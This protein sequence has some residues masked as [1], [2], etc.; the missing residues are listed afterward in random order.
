MP[1]GWAFG[2]RDA[3]GVTRMLHGAATPAPG[4]D[5][6]P[7]TVPR[8]RLRGLA[9]RSRARTAAEL[10]LV[11]AGVGGST[12]LEIKWATSQP[13]VGALA[14]APLATLVDDLAW[15]ADNGLRVM[16]RTYAG[17]YAPGFVR[18]AAGNIAPW[19]SKDNPPTYDWE[20]IPGGL[21]NWTKPAFA[22]AYRDWNL[23]LRDA[24]GDHAAL[25]AVTMSLPMTEYAEPCLKQY[26][27]AANRASA[28]AAGITTD[29][30]LDAFERGFEI[31]KEV[32]SAAG[33]ATACAY[34][35]HQGL[36]AA[37]EM[38]ASMSRT[39]ALMDRQLAILGKF[40]VWENNSLMDP[41][42]DYAPM[43]AKMAEGHA[44]PAK[45]VTLHFQTRTTD[46]HK[47]AWKPTAKTSP[48][49]T[50]ARAVALGA[51]SVEFP[52]GGMDAVSKDGATIWDAF[53]LAQAAKVNSDLAANTP[54]WP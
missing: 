2:Y 33:V 29:A 45:K 4:P 39:L 30:D 53:T 26:S 43:Y 18:T 54:V 21:A 16:L 28:K 1:E 44:D 15:A 24:I 8:V 10:P 35:T 42:D 6:E 34:N 9:G 7:F 20:A 47:I 19:Y 25:A 52:T 3:G 13:A 41:D 23:R 12:V 32:W 46:K 27:Y 37:G 5:P 40:C 48:A 14:A 51:N 11:T 31:H 36:N 22:T 50:F 17:I 38:E 49:R